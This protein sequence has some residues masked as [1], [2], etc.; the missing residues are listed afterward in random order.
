MNEI[1]IAFGKEIYQLLFIA[2]ILFILY[3]IGNFGFSIYKILK[4]DKDE[5]Y[6]HYKYDSVLYWIAITMILTYII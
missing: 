2:S 5:K 1:I 4:L 6:I 3:K